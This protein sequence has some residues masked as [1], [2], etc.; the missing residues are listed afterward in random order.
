MATL[1]RTKVAENGTIKA[2]AD[3]EKDQKTKSRQAE[4]RLWG[5]TK[6]KDAERAPGATGWVLGGSFGGAHSAGGHRFG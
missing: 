4:T 3:R 6:Y 2:G 5:N 1:S